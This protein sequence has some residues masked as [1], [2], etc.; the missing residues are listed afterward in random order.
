MIAASIL[1]ARGFDNI[2]NIEGGLGEI[3]KTNL[4]IEN[5]PPNP[6]L[7]TGGGVPFYFGKKLPDEKAPRYAVAACF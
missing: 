2:I 5:H 6:L 3:A 7:K 4:S 1:K